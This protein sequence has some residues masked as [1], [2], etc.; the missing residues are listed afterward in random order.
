MLTLTVTA[1]YELNW[2]SH[3]VIT[4]AALCNLETNCERF[5]KCDIFVNDAMII[6]KCDRSSVDPVD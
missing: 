4:P 5:S 2:W 3:F 6:T 1:E